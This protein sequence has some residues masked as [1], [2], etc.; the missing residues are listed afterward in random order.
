MLSVEYN[1]CIITSKQ[2]NQC[3]PKALFPC[4]VQYILVFIINLL[5]SSKKAKIIYSVLYIIIIILILVVKYFLT[6]I[7]AIIYNLPLK[8]NFI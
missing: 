2:A 4:V 5:Y 7:V 3:T 1:N 8:L 6:T